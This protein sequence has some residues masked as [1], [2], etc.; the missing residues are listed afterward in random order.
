MRSDQDD[1]AVESDVNGREGMF[2]TRC[3]S[4]SISGIFQCDGKIWLIV[5]VEGCETIRGANLRVRLIS[6]Y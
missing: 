4:N 2:P 3:L 5:E 1:I 6:P